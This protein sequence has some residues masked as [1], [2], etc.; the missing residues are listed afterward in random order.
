LLIA[1]IRVFDWES[2]P[3]DIQDSVWAYLEERVFPI[4]SAIGGFGWN[5]ADGTRWLDAHMTLPLIELCHLLGRAYPFASMFSQRLSPLRTGSG[6]GYNV[7]LSRDAGN[8]YL[9]LGIAQKI[10]WSGLS[11]SKMLTYF[12]DTVR[13]VDST[14]ADITYAARGWASLA[15]MTPEMRSLLVFRLREAS[16]EQIRSESPAVLSLMYEFRLSA[17]ETGLGFLLEEVRSQL[18]QRLAA[19]MRMDLLWQLCEADALLGEESLGAGEVTDFVAAQQLANGGFR[20]AAELPEDLMGFSDVVS[21]YLAIEILM[22]YDVVDVV[23][24]DSLASFIEECRYGLGY[25]IAPIDVLAAA[26][27]PLDVDFFSTYYGIRLQHFA[28]T[29][30][31]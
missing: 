2:S 11:H 28:E 1:S 31:L 15:G 16:A 9:A 12:R 7:Q 24:R 4:V 19:S 3:Q 26:G 10:G 8:S 6:W 25:L 27:D 17:R 5:S 29:G 21:T 14:F 30:S 23:P 22:Y 13:A 18:L 20:M